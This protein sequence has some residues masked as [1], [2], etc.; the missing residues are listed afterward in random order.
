MVTICKKNL[1]LPITSVY[2]E[3]CILYI[4]NLMQNNDKTILVDDFE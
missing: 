4:K 1:I 3:C 2:K